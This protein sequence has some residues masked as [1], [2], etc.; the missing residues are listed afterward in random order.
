M[1]NVKDFRQFIA[2]DYCAKNNLE[3]TNEGFIAADKLWHDATVRKSKKAQKEI[4]VYA[5]KYRGE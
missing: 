4:G 3:D 1:G 2:E 5:K